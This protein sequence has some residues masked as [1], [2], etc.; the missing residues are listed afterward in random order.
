MI[1]LKKNQYKG[2][3]IYIIGNGPSL[4]QIDMNRLR[5]EYTFSF[6]RAYIAYEKWGFHPTFYM[7]LDKV[8][9]PDNV[10]ELNE[11]ISSKAAQKTT[12]FFPDWIKP[13]IQEKENTV[14]FKEELSMREGFCPGLDKLT[15]L[16][17][18]GSTSI[19]LA[20]WLGFQKIVLLGCDCNYVEKPD[21]VKINQEAS[22]QVGWTAYTSK[23]DQDPNHFLPDYFGKGKSYSIPNAPNHLKGWKMVY[24]W[25][26]VNNI[27][28]KDKINIL[29][30]SEI[31]KIPY[32]KRVK[33]SEAEA[34]TLDS[35]QNDDL[36]ETIAIYGVSET[37]KNFIK[38]KGYRYSVQYLVDGDKEK[39]GKKFFGVPIKK[40]EALKKARD[41]DFILITIQKNYED[42]IKKL[43]KWGFKGKIKH[44]SSI[45]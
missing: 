7:C 34:C 37:A 33:I 44:F 41:L 17:N 31:S 30:V 26:Y 12:F 10:M 38:E 42:V 4:N 32:F 27:V 45:E 22:N 15:V 13:K 19:Q 6:N 23:T 40:P 2:K 9:L 25:M 5:G 3:T 18:V 1:K 8:V 36:K 24:D 43:E 16:Y 11:L 21:N 29:N 39:I 35:L 14:F 20:V 28:N